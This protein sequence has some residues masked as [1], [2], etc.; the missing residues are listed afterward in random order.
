MWGAGT[1]ANVY[2]NIYGENGD[3]GERFLRKSN[4]LNK[5]ES[6]QVGVSD[7]TE[8]CHEK[9]TVVRDPLPVFLKVLEPY[10]T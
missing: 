8:T 3:T 9:N 1:D 10:R 2:V 4:Y 6:G 7:Y 5:F